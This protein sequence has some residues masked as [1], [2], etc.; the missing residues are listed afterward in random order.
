MAVACAQL[1]LQ[2]DHDIGGGLER[3]SHEIRQGR[4]QCRAI[5]LDLQEDVGA[6]DDQM[7][8]DRFQRHDGGVDLTE[9]LRN[10][11]R[12]P[13]PVSAGEDQHVLHQPIEAVQPLDPAFQKP[14]AAL[15]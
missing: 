6:V 4:H 12:L 5:A 10:P 11:H 7:R 13:T 15:L 9:E 2:G 14:R 1:G 8:V 3:V